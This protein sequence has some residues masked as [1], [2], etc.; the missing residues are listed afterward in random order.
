LQ[1]HYNKEGFNAAPIT[2]DIAKVHSCSKARIGI[3]ANNEGDCRTCDSRIGIGTG[4][5]S[6]ES[7]TC[8]NQAVSG[9]DNGEK[10]I[11]SMGYVLVQ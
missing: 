11:K 9:G 4:G 2:C 5:H 3:I 1:P 6:D 8:G 10:H 7:N